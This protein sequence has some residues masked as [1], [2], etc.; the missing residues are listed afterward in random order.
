MK[1]IV[2]GSGVGE[3]EVNIET[4]VIPNYSIYFY[5]QSIFT[6]QVLFT[7]SE[8]YNIYKRSDVRGFH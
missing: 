8:I 7:T 6:D 5:L 2:Q 4:L 1:K 3:E